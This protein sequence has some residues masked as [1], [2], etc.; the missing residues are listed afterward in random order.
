VASFQRQDNDNGTTCTVGSSRLKTI[1]IMG[2]DGSSPVLRDHKRNNSME[3]EAGGTIRKKQ[4]SQN[5][6]QQQQQQQQEQHLGSNSQ[7][8][9]QRANNNNGSN[10]SSSSMVLSDHLGDTSHIVE[11]M[12]HNNQVGQHC[13]WSLT[14]LSQAQQPNNNNNKKGRANKQER[15]KAARH[16][17]MR[18]FRAPRSIGQT[19]HGEMSE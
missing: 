11:S 4:R 5:Q 19:N 2:D 14:S 3:E 1:I 10:F 17:V 12:T 8:L 18:V 7:W 15:C 9:F 16:T 6:N 13:N